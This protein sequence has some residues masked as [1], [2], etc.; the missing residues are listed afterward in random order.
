MTQGQR[1]R[2]A[3]LP[4]RVRR[5]I[6]YSVFDR[7]G[8]VDD[9]IVHSL[10]ALREHAAR[11]LVVVNGA[12][13][14]DSRTA[15]E[16]VADEVLQ[17]ENEGFDIGA[18]RA[19]LHRLGGEIAQYDE[20]VLTN[21]T[22]YG[23]TRPWAP[24]FERMGRT[25][26]DFWGLTDH[27]PSRSNP[28]TRRGVA[29][30]HQQ[31]YWI[32]VRRSMF[33]S[34]EWARYWAELPPLRTY[35]DAVV[36]HELRFTQH[37]VE[38]G[39]VAAAAYPYGEFDT[40]NPSLF[41]AETLI[42]R[43]CPVLK[44]RPLFHWPPLLDAHAAVGAWTLSEAAAGGYPTGLIL[45]NLARTVPPKAMNVDAGLLTVLPPD[46][47]RGERAP[48][49]VRPRI[50][51][52]VHT[53]GAPVGEALRRAEMLGDDVDLVV[54]TTDAGVHATV[55]EA[56]SQRD[57]SSRRPAQVRLVSPDASP[58]GA[59]LLGCRD[60][61]DGDD[62][63]LVVR[64]RACSPTGIGAEGSIGEHIF[65][66]LLPDP[67]FAASVIELFEAEPTLG[68]VYPPLLHIGRVAIGESWDALKPAFAE[69]AR[70]LGITVPLDD[71]S[72]LA[73]AEG[74]FV[75]RVEALRLFAEAHWTH[76]AL[77]ASETLPSLIELMWSSGVGQLGFHTRTVASRDLI[78]TSHAFLEYDLDRMS[79]TIPGRA[80]QKIDFLRHSGWS[81]AG[82]G[83][84]L[85]RMYVRRRHAWFVRAAR[86]VMDPARFPARFVPPVVRR[87]LRRER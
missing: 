59:F 11:I 42:E 56:V 72:A 16:S 77:S 87:T 81:G 3:T 66:N 82:T 43:G 13:S 41:E 53:D 23:P 83:G 63:D 51:A 7:D 64:L 68:I 9:F 67:E 79:Q 19:A 34:A 70:A 73:P 27:G 6:V 12:L 29:P 4:E 8:R 76:D 84:D 25:A 17:R 46:G 54:T 57:A 33:L 52:V 65:G 18:H 85:L 74:M 40:E 28:F 5:L 30:Y 78:A 22:W 39:R 24:V 50:V 45:G 37:F 69:Q 21:D 1:S 36:A 60:V 58:A 35:V 2:G 80:F 75:A 71:V 14:P 38:S 15:L 48:G 62:Y 26:C 55:V 44:R 86:R 47:P 20:I 32:A 61:L 49:H 31:S 10:P